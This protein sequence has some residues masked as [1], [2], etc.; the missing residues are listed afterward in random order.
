MGV[1]DLP[2]GLIAL[3]GVIA[4]LAYGFMRLVQQRRFYKDL[5]RHY[6]HCEM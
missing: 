6:T 4:A 5:V 2:L 3:S 1:R